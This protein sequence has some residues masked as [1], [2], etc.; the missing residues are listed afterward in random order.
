MDAPFESGAL[1]G[2]R[3]CPRC[4]GALEPGDG[5]RLDCVRC[6]HR[7]YPT[8]SPTASALI[9]RDRRLLLARRGGE[10]FAGWWDMPGGFVA[11]GESGED[12]LRRELAEETG[13][14]IEV[15]RFLGAFPDTYG[16]G[17]DGPPTFNLF[18]LAEALGDGEPEAADDVTEVAWFARGELP[19]RIA[20]RCTHMALRAAGW[21]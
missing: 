2:Y 7:L 10:P 8:P 14:E 3:F 6:G 20:F 5:G 9:V 21:A 17:E 4:A 19:D 16:G 1:A 13:L 18:W 11:P 15:G 12:A